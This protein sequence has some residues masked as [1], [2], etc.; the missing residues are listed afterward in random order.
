[1][2]SLILR[3]LSKTFDENSLSN[4]VINDFSL[5]INQGDSIAFI[6]KSGAGKSTLLHL[7]AKLES[8][9]SGTV[10]VSISDKNYDYANMTSNQIGKLR[11]HHY[12]FVYQQHHLLEDL[13][14]LENCTLPCELKTKGNINLDYILNLFERMELLPVKDRYPN[15]LSGGER[16][17]V[18][19]IRAVAH[20]PNFLF[21]DEPTGN[22]DQENSYTIQQLLQGLT[23]LEKMGVILAT[24]EKNFAK[25]MKRGF[26]IQ[27]GNIWQ[28]K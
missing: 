23:N 18:A 27:N 25:R 28:K 4:R 8:A 12:G 17:R 24:H 22:L 10:E 11:L 20:K 7:M 14:C 1:M 6:G 2:N 15:T 19:I 16:Q 5:T 13:T 9:S 3:K 21:L 26:E